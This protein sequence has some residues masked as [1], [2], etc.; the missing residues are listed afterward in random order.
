[1]KNHPF[2]DKKFK[3]GVESFILMYLNKYQFVMGSDL[4]LYSEREKFFTDENPCN[5]YFILRRPKVSVDPNSS[6]IK[7]KNASL[8]FFIH[9]EENKIKCSLDF[10]FKEAKG[11][12]IFFTKYPYNLFT[13][14][15]DSGTHFI[16]RPSTVLDTESLRIDSE[17]DILDYEILYIGQAYGK[18][19]KRTAIDR[20]AAHET[21]QRIYADSLTTYPDS[22]IWIMLTNFTQM[23][24]LVSGDSDETDE[25][26]IVEDS[27]I[28]HIFTNNGIKFSEKQIINFTEAALIKYFEPKY[29]IEFKDSFPSTKHT[30]YSECYELDVRAIG[31]EINSDEMTKKIYTNKT[32][33]LSRH[34][35]NFEFKSSNDRFNLF[36]YS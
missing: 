14:S 29:N 17:N 23:S 3:Y 35:Q 28:E 9:V 11:K 15:S 31:I 26:K 18:D 36:N 16:A 32:G 6:I 7:G 5:I 13:F 27:K 21:L 22:D 19:G 34:F 8:D 20:L 4:P 30:S 24:L 33:R 1:M 25:T 12:L 2:I 10:K